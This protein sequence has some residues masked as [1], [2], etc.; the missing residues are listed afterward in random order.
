MDDVFGLPQP[1]TG[2]ETVTIRQVQNGQS[3]LCTMPLSSLISI[4]TLT[5]LASSLPTARPSVS[6]VVW[7]NGGV[8]SIS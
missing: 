1:I 7:N 4:I 5:A 6:G 2:S 3:A 8:V